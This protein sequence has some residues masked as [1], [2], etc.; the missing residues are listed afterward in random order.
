MVY[1]SGLQSCRS[2]PKLTSPISSQEWWESVSSALLGWK[3]SSPEVSWES[4]EGER[5][6]PPVSE[7][8]TID[9]LSGC[10][11]P[12]SMLSVILI[13]TPCLPYCLSHFTTSA[14]SISPVR[15]ASESVCA[16]CWPVTGQPVR[17]ACFAMISPPCRRGRQTGDTYSL[18][19]ALS[20]SFRMARSESK[21]C[22]S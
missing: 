20:T 15:V 16:L 22:G 13:G 4:A 18:I 3:G 1:R 6:I 21:T 2:Y 8:Q 11:R 14:T 10:C 5:M 7:G 19:R 17:K 12:H 9:R